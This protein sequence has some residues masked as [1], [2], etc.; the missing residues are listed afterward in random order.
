[1]S[2]NDIEDDVTSLNTVVE[3][4]GFLFS[5]NRRFGNYSVPSKLGNYQL[6]EVGSSRSIKRAPVPLL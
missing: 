4:S 1:M 5:G 2:E 3:P 6:E